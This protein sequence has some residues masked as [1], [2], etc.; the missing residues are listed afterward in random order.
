MNGNDSLPS[1][2]PRPTGMVCRLVRQI[3]AIVDECNYAHRRLAMLR[4]APDRGLPGAHRA[5]DTYGDFLFRTSGPMVHE[6]S[7]RDRATGRQPEL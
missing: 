2:A 4:M 6:P 3:C 7:A 5:P 1:A